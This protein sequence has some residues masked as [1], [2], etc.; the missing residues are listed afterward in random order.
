MRLI[1]LGTP[2]FA[3]PTLKAIVE[4]GHEVPA[5]A[6]GRAPRHPR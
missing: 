5:V 1:F 3:V 6:G 4:A 2:A